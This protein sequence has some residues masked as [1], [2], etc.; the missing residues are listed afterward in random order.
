MGRAGAGAAGHRLKL[1]LRED[2]YCRFRDKIRPFGLKTAAAFVRQ[3]RWPQANIPATRE[4]RQ[5]WK[6]A[7]CRS[8]R[9][10]GVPFTEHYA[11]PCPVASFPLG[12]P[13]PLCRTPLSLLPS[14]T[15]VTA[16]STV[17]LAAD[18]LHPRVPAAT[19]GGGYFPPGASALCIAKQNSRRLWS[20]A[21]L[22]P[23][24]H[25]TRRAERGPRGVRRSRAA[26][27]HQPSRQR[28]ALRSKH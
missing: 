9:E 8:D 26:A 28:L 6:T 18:G 16:S 21:T 10:A 14:Y 1:P 22:R 15:P 12:E 7:I 23:P 4:H 24:I 17:W 11:R 27:C 13:S 20:S 3:E 2:R 25:P 19:A 5:L